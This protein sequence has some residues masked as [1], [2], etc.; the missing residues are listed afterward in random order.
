[1]EITCDD[2]RGDGGS[3]GRHLYKHISGLIV[4]SQL[5]VELEA[6]E[7][8]FQVLD[9]FAVCLHLGVVTV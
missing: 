7:F 9:G 8:L 6:V 4:L 5:I 2:I 1:M 3:F